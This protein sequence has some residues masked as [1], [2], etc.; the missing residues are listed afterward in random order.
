MA[1]TIKIVSSKSE[2]KKFIYYPLELHKGHKNWVPPIFSEEFAFYDPTKNKSLVT[3]DHILA[4]AYD[5]NRIIGRVMGIINKHYNE[6]YNIKDARFF[7]IECI[8]DQQVMHELIEFVKN[9]AVSKGM[10]RL[11]GP[12]GFSDK[13][14]QGFMIEGYEQIPLIATNFNFPYMVQLLENEGFTKEVD[15]LSYKMVIPETI[16]DLYEHVLQRTLKNHNLTMLDFKR[17]RDLKQYIVP[18]F[19]LVNEAYSPIYG[20]VPLDEQEMKE[21]AEKYFMILDREF[22]KVIIDANN[23]VAA[24]IVAIPNMSKGISKAKGKLFPFGFIHILKAA[25]NTDQLD[26]FLGAV[27]DKY[28]NLGL[29]AMMG[30]SVFE[31]AHKRK[32]KIID[33]HLILENNELMK[34]EIE[35]LGGVVYKR[36]RV[37][38]KSISKG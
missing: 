1:V 32:L 6:I 16:P 8:N 29:D 31:S 5:N 3:N 17:K 38:Q 21:M 23:E 14:P 7:A 19:R 20:F 36:Y 35:K 11:V 4:L 25:R 33:S 26:L 12:Y 22:V 18:V 2:L 15:C 34:A 30:K 13:D 10:T 28:R 9:W 37:Y 24:F 27:K